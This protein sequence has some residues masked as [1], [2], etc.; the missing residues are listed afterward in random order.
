MRIQGTKRTTPQNKVAEAKPVD[1]ELA[2]DD[3]SRFKDLVTKGAYASGGALAGVGLGVATGGVMSNLMGTSSLMTAGGVL[4][5]IAGAGTAVSLAD[6]E[7]KKETLTKVALG[8][9][10]ASIG[11]AAGQFLGLNVLGPL[12]TSAGMPS[13]ATLAPF[14]GTATGALTGAAIPN[15]ESSGEMLKLVR[16]GA[17]VS[18]LGSIGL[19]LGLAGKLWAIRTP[20]MEHMGS[21][22][23]ILGAATGAAIGHSIATDN[24]IAD[25]VARTSFGTSAGYGVGS[26]VGGIAHSIGGSSLYTLALPAAGALAGSLTAYATRSYGESEVPYGH[27][28]GIG[29]TVVGSAAAG[30]LAGDALGHL[31]TAATGHSLY[32]QMGFLVGGLNGA[33]IGSV[34]A[35]PTEITRKAAGFSLLTT[36]GLTVGALAGS[37]LTA[38]TGHDVY[39]Q[40]G[41]AL[42]ALNG[43]AGGLEAIGIDTKKGQPILLSGTAGIGGGALVGSALSAITGHSVY[44]Q[45]GAVAG[46]VSGALLAVDKTGLLDTR[47]G[48]ETLA[49]ATAGTGVGALLGSSLDYLTGQQIWGVA[50]PVLGAAAG[51]LSALAVS[52]GD[53][54]GDEE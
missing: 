52:F 53:G 27:E 48:A 8:W 35:A 28:A 36:S 18:V 16:H 34:I 30:T 51:G 26:V 41:S 1:Q 25:R 37:A 40:F 2:G 7:N 10:G 29:A 54:G 19:T 12:A 49:G 45:M 50:L 46:G 32:S 31:L 9:G 5:A 20:G 44:G 4:G 23:P 13:V 42:G 39:N 47:G 11:S 14:L 15:I 17:G 24:V 43:A 38:A 6:S 22:G 33:G 21:F 3:E